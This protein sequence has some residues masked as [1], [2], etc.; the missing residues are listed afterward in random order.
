MAR[1]QTRKS[2]S[3]R[4]D[5]YRRLVAWCDARG[6]TAS[7]FVEERIA[8]VAPPPPVIV[9]P[10]PPEEV[11]ELTCDECTK[12]FTR[13]ISV[14]RRLKAKGRKAQCCS[15]ACAIAHARTHTVQQLGMKRAAPAPA[16]RFSAQPSRPRSP[17]Q[18]IASDNGKR[19][20]E[21]RTAQRA[22]PTDKPLRPPV[23]LPRTTHR[24][25][26]FDPA[27]KHVAPR[28]EGRKLVIAPRLG[29]PREF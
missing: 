20:A 21:V 15:A 10:A 27:R 8:E 24:D 9:A 11:V 19:E 23:P 14:V 6:T 26:V 2:I 18:S 13:A 17:V 3:V 25:V 5:S 29:L 12:K 4:G 7:A 28:V 22:A 16:P 1:K